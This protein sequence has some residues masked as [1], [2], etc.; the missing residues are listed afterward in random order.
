MSDDSMTTLQDMRERLAAA[1]RTEGLPQDTNFEDE[2]DWNWVDDHGEVTRL[3]ASEAPMPM[4]RPDADDLWS[5]E[6]RTR[7]RFITTSSGCPP[8]IVRC[9]NCLI[10]SVALASEFLDDLRD[11]R[12]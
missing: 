4:P 12:A 9:I 7:I 1:T 6:Q 8:R 10:T 5:L 3:D 2:W 11:V